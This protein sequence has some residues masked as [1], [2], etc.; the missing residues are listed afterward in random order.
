MRCSIVVAALISLFASA[1]PGAVVA[2]QPCTEDG[3]CKGVLLCRESRCVQVHCKNDS[4]CPAGRMC[5]EELCR[6]RQCYTDGDCSIDRLCGDGFCVVPQPV[7]NKFSEPV[8]PGVVRGA[9]GPFFPLGLQA[10]VD[11]PLGDNR[12]VMLGLGTTISDGGLSWKI[13]LRGAPLRWEAFELDAW[14]GAMGFN[15]ASSPATVADPDAADAPAADPV[16]A[17]LG[18]GR[19][20]F[21]QGR[22]V[23][24]VWW[25]GG[26]GVTIPHGPKKRRFLR[27][28]MGLLLLFDDVYPKERDFAVLPAFGLLYGWTFGQK[29]GD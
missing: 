24:A 18:S 27:V 13:G 17:L 3:D 8:A 6:T 12:W 11:V 22:A 21:A 25:G 1:F 28:D 2:A 19:F 26:A 14:A 16:A 29:D 7:S 15:V 4:Q 9:V 10:Q 23:H 5:H 20:L